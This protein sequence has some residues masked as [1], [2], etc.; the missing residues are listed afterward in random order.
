M[1]T[2]LPALILQVIF[3]LESRT[4]WINLGYWAHTNRYNEAC[5]ALATLVGDAAELSE[6]DHVLGRVMVDGN[7][8]TRCMLYD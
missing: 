5:S 3:N 1:R 8:L 6:A 4:T 7:M 2:I